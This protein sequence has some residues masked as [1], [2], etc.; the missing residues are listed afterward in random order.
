[1]EPVKECDITWIIIK[2]TPDKIIAVFRLEREENF[3]SFMA[4]IKF[5]SKVATVSD[6]K[7]N[8]ACIESGVTH[9][10]FHS[11]SS[12]RPYERIDPVSYIAATSTS[13]LVGKGN[14][15]SS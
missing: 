12:F 15:T 6:D 14:Q 3:N 11:K 10:F 1:M 9:H 8:D 7:C 5:R 13:K 4:K 2:L